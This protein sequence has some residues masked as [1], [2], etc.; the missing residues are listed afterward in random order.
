[1]IDKVEKVKR[2]HVNWYQI[3]FDLDDPDIKSRFMIFLCDH[4]TM[5][6]NRIAYN[7]LKRY[8]SANSLNRVRW[9]GVPLEQEPRKEVDDSD[10]YSTTICLGL[11]HKR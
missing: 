10:L 3:L 11:G 6:R 1:M 8:Y 2:P 9:L 4:K 7:V 5:S